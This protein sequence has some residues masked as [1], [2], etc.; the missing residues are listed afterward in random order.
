MKARKCSE[1]GCRREAREPQKG[2]AHAF[3]GEH[4]RKALTAAFGEAG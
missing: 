3:C 4:E 1:P 2:V